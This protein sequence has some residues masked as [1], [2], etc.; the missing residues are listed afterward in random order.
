MASD[1]MSVDEG[2]LQSMCRNF[3]VVIKLEELMTWLKPFPNRKSSARPT[4][5]PEIMSQ[6]AR[7]VPQL[8]NVT[9]AHTLVIKST[10][11]SHLSVVID[12]F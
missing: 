10:P 4:V 3:I 6:I 11:E 5:H 9:Y 2:Y 7:E 1:C 8:A 12:Q